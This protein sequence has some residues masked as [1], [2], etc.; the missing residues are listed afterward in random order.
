MNIIQILSRRIQLL[1]LD[2]TKTYQKTSLVRINNKVGKRLK[3]NKGKCSPCKL[4]HPSQ[5]T[6]TRQKGLFYIGSAEFRKF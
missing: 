4:N 5:K 2:K 1:Y 3:Q 6:S